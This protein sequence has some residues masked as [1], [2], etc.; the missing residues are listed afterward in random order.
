M[1]PATLTLTINA[2]AKVLTRID[3]RNNEG[4]L[5]QL[6]SAT[7]KITL[8][9]RHST[10]KSKLTPAN[11]DVHNVFFE[12]TIYATPTSFVENYKFSATFRMIES[13]DPVKLGYLV[14][15]CNTLVAANSAAIIAGDS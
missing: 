5:Y 12:H 8:Q 1:L 11:E 14:A 4:S 9:V 3:P 15:A 7:E 6:K 2:V 13:N 10:A